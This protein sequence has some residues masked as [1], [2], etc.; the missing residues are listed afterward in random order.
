[1]DY[2]KSWTGYKWDAFEKHS[3]YSEDQL[4][5]FTSRIPIM[6]PTGAKEELSVFVFDSNDW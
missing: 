5:W 2:G 6:D 3:L 4:G 1:M